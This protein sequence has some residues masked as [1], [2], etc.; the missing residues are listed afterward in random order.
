[1]CVRRAPCSTPLPHPTLFRSGPEIGGDVGPER[2]EVGHPA[3]VDRILPRL[4]QLGV[5][6][7]ELGA[8]LVQIVVDEG[9]ASQI[10]ALA[11]AEEADRKSTRLNS[12]H[13]KISYAVC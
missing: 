2:P 1:V 12:S 13:V 6:R 9:D 8:L 10:V 5:V 7:L 3:R 11:V 4:E